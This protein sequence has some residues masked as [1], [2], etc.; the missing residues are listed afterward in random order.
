M[1]DATPSLQTV[2]TR[3]LRRIRGRGAGAVVTA[4]DFLDLGGRSS[5]DWVLSRLVQKGTLRRLDRG[6]YHYPRLHAHLGELAPSVEAIVKALAG[7]DDLRLLPSPAYAANLLQ[8]S[9]QVPA[10]IVFFTDGLSRKVKFGQQ[11]IELRRTTPRNLRAAGRAS[12]L[13]IQAMKFFGKEGVASAD[14]EALRSRLNERERREIRE[15]LP[16]APTWMQPHLR[17]L[18]QEVMPS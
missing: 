11:A 9:L 10:K 2:S 16:F 17:A 4:R 14:L 1:S 12:G 6:L 15:D 13:V 18:A 3:V 5:V 7:R 8:L